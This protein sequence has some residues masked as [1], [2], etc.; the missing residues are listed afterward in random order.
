MTVPTF[1][2]TNGVKIPAVGYGTGTKWFKKVDSGELDE[3]VV[4]AVA[5]AISNGYTHIDGAEVYNT[6]P[7]IGAAI[8]KSGVDRKKLFITTKVLPHIANPE[9]ALNDSLSK[10]GVDYVDLYLIHA[11]F[12]TEKD[13]G[14]SLEAAW[15]KLE[16]FYAAG[17]VKAIG[18]SNFPV[19]SIEKILKVAKVKPQVHQIEYNAYLQNQTP[20]VVK[21]SQDHGILVEAY[22]PLGP[23]IVKDEAAPLTPVLKKLGEKYKKT[24][25]QIELRWTY[26]NGVLPITTSANSERQKEPLG[27]FDFELTKEEVKE[28]TTVGV[29]YTFRQYWKPQFEYKNSL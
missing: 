5:L 9:K 2:L 6:E 18:I 4:D 1:T 13:N 17:K 11:P 26:Q 24:P 16:E 12:V 10:L 20:G 7:E 14:I 21:F 25:A 22:S 28:I 15:A 23:I 27:I 3:K 8:K 19:E 29:T